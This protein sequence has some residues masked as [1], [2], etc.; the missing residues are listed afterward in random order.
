[1]FNSVIHP[2]NTV[3]AVLV[4]IIV[5]KLK[6][7]KHHRQT[8]VGHFEAALCPPKGHSLLRGPNVVGVLLCL[9]ARRARV[10]G[11]RPKFTDR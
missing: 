1:M 2:R 7:F 8:V 11:N 6:H 4:M 9:S 5:I 10:E 3:C